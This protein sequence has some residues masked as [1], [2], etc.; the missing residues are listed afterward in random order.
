MNV[1][2]LIKYYEGGMVGEEEVIGVSAT[3]KYAKNWCK[4]EAE[5]H[6]RLCLKE[7]PYRQ[8]DFEIRQY[9]GE[10]EAGWESYPYRIFVYR[11][12]TLR[13]YKKQMIVCEEKRNG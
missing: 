9:K 2:L 4:K 8:E 6:H 5:K 3:K 7:H 10:K 11:R 13:D 12:V 1:Y